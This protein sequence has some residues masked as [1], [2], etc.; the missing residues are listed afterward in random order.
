MKNND[1]ASAIVGGAFFAIP[2]L[3]LSVPLLP[4]LAIAGCAFGAGELVFKKEKKTLKDTDF[5]LFRA[6][7][8]AKR[9]NKHIAEMIPKIEDSAVKCNLT[10][11]KESVDKIISTVE[12]NPDRV[13]NIK[14]FFEYYLP[15][16]IKLVDR[17]DEIENQKIKSK[18]NDA[19]KKNTCEMI[20]EINSVFKKFLNNLYSSDMTDTK[21]EIKVLNSMLKADGLDQ[22]EL[23]KE[24]D[25][26]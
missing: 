14:N 6:I 24:D 13:K 4:S 16:T 25:H 17:F 3:A 15:V 19:F 8:S 23:I 12:K 7:E 10:E 21:V 9:Q 1:I 11:I 5:N 18:D 22:N 20:T 26:E 2:Y